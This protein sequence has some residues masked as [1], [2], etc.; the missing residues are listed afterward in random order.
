M[1]EAER[2][3]LRPGSNGAESSTSS[4]YAEMVAS[5]CC[6]S[7]SKRP[8]SSSS[9]DATNGGYAGGMNRPHDCASKMENAI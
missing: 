7:T 6:R 8:R 2:E 5:V 1:L 3:S 9:V 4:L